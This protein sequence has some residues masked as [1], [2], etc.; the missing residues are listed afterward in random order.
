MRRISKVQWQLAA[1]IDVMRLFCNP[2]AHPDQCGEMSLEMASNLY[3][4]AHASLVS[5]YNA[6]EAA[7]RLQHGRM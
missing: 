6:L 2:K 1:A 4:T 3:T 5:A 7:E